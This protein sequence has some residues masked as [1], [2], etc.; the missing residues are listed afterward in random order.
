MKLPIRRPVRRSI[1]QTV[2]GSYTP[3][4]PETIDTAEA[5]IVSQ[6]VNFWQ[7]M[8]AVSSF[9]VTTNC[10]N[11]DALKTA[12]DAATSTASGSIA[13]TQKH[14]IICDWDGAST[15]AGN[16]DTQLLFRGYTGRSDGHLDNG[17]GIY[18]VAAA[19]KQPTILNRVDISGIKG[20]HIDGVNFG[21]TWN[22]VGDPKIQ[23]CLSITKNSTRPTHPVTK[24]TNCNFGGEQVGAPQSEWITGIAHLSGNADYFELDGGSVIGA[25]NGI[26]T[27]FCRRVWIHD[28]DHQLVI[29]DFTNHFGFTDSDETNDYYMYG[30][31]ERNTWRNP[32]DGV[33]NRNNHQDL[34]QTGTAADLHLGYRMVIRD[35]LGHANH[36]FAGDA[37]LGG[38]TQGYYN[39]DHLTADNQFVLR[40]NTFL[41]TSPGAFRYWSPRATHKS[42]LDRCTFTRAGMVPSGLPGDVNTPEDFNVGI[43]SGDAGDVGDPVNDG[44]VWCEVSNS[45]LGSFP[46]K[47][48]YHETNVAR[49]DPRDTGT[50][51]DTTIR[52][53]GVFLGGGVGFV[54]GE[55]SAGK[56]SYHLPG[57]D[58]GIT[59][60][61]SSRTRGQYAADIWDM[62]EPQAAHATQGCPDLSSLFETPVAVVGDPIFAEVLSSTPIV[63][64][65][66]TNLVNPN[67]WVLEVTFMG[68][69]INQAATPSAITVT[70]ESPGYTNGVAD[71]KTRTI[72]GTAHLRKPIPPT[73]A[74]GQ[75]PT[76]GARR[77][78]KV[79]NSQIY[80]CTQVGGGT[81]ANAPT[82]TSGTV[83]GADGYGWLYIGKVSDNSSSILTYMPKITRDDGA[84]NCK[85]PYV[86]S[87]EIYQ[88][89]TITSITVNAGAYGA[90]NAS[91]VG[92][93]TWANHSTLGY[94]PIF[95]S[96]LYY[97]WDIV[98][99]TLVNELVVMHQ[100]GRSGRPVD[101]VKF[102]VRNAAGAVAQT[103]AL[104][105]DLSLA[106]VAT[107]GNKVQ[108]YKED[109]NIT[110]LADA[111]FYSR[112][113]EVYPWIGNPYKSHDDGLGVAA[114]SLVST[115][116]MTANVSRCV[117]FR[118]DAANAFGRVYAY[119]DP[120]SGNDATGQ[121]STNS[122]TA[123]GLP[124][125][126]V[127]AAI[128]T[129]TRG[130]QAVSNTTFSRNNYSNHVVRLKAGT[131]TNTW[132][133][134]L[135]ASVAF[136]DVPITI[137][138]DP[139]AVAGSVDIQP[140]ATVNNKKGPAR[141]IYR[142][143]KFSGTGSAA[144]LDNQVPNTV[145]TM[146]SESVF[147]NCN[148]VGSGAQRPVARIGLSWCYDCTHSGGS[149][150]WWNDNNSANKLTI[151]GTVSGGAQISP[152]NCF[153]TVFS[154]ASIPAAP[155]AKYWGEESS[156]GLTQT[157]LKLMMWGFV[158]WPS[159]TAIPKY[160]NGTMGTAATTP[161]TAPGN[162]PAGSRQGI[163]VGA[164]MFM[165]EIETYD[166]GGDVP[167]AKGG[168]F[169]ADSVTEPMPYLLD[170]WGQ[171]PGEGH[172]VLYCEN[173]LTY[174]VKNGV[175]AYNV[176]M[177]HNMKADLYEGGAEVADEHR[178]GNFKVRY[179]VN[180]RKMAIMAPTD[181]LPSPKNLTGE[182]FPT[183]WLVGGAA[184]TGG[185]LNPQYTNDKSFTSTG[186]Q[187]GGGDYRP[188]TS[189]PHKGMISAAQQFWKY[190][191]GGV[192]RKTDGTGVPGPR[193]WA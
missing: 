72:T 102:I 80:S 36:S 1:S 178:V 103:G 90:S 114:G 110:G 65:P 48:W 19:G 43:F 49:C 166:L 179:N 180:S 101:S 160:A 177:D 144:A 152:I 62:F 89:D 115:T 148:I 141:V 107:T 37:G 31:V 106:T 117:P 73:W 120:V 186:A 13:I 118:K 135:T 171:T 58:G 190:D 33:A 8:S 125:V 133:G 172:N 145:G 100:H 82:H 4:T 159:C 128:K 76:V 165:Y 93:L 104:I 28:A 41:V 113:F 21:G 111:G 170:M 121:A 126:S 134:D 164:A 26:T 88:G 18:I 156:G 7:G 46:V 25:Q 55:Y 63:T 153:G 157:D 17:G 129:A 181:A 51:A 155:A 109:M 84:G 185:A 59:G 192:A 182:V 173:G 137:E 44:S 74:A 53:E 108:C 136:V 79:T 67:G 81:T 132:G 191:L 130:I 151:G 143:L 16:V 124:F 87:D 122:A 20:I 193:E 34:G 169:S 60:A 119:V 70:V 188:T 149:V 56:L 85:V 167:S 69:A 94:P 105:T 71:T 75:S 6:V 52:P 183:D 147:I 61:A 142:G 86:L 83:V 123:A 9:D 150:S 15:Y 24:V 57:E 174:F 112:E 176:Q 97:P 146:V 139:A 11:A 45:I 10:A 140:S 98:G 78:R 32:V 54:R 96:P 30:V 40:R 138:I 77:I 27:G 47:T 158:T 23:Y 175:V 2:K 39:D 5:F 154:A 91:R 35:N 184:G 163:T 92:I 68:M 187:T 14:K 95:V 127:S 29:R 50:V 66:E 22:G 168:E 161:G 189:S 3:A 38:G 99:N 162:I 64:S 42:F 131:Y 116:R 12:I